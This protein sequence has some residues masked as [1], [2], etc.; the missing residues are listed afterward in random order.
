MYPMGMLPHASSHLRVPAGKAALSSA[1]ESSGKTR[2][3]MGICARR[4]QFFRCDSTCLGFV[5]EN[6]AAAPFP[7]RVCRI[8][9]RRVGDATRPSAPAAVAS[10]PLPSRLPLVAGQCLACQDGSYALDGG[11]KECTPCPLGRGFCPGTS[12]VLPEPGHWQ[13]QRCRS[14]PKRTANHG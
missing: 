8:G 14:S 1:L 7:M 11:G 9:S 12:I 6:G 5:K 10:G 4:V 13:A 3:L 2:A